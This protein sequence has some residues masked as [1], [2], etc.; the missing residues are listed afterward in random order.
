MRGWRRAWRAVSAHDTG[1]LT[2]VPAPDDEIEGLVAGVAPEEWQILDTREAFYDRHDVTETIATDPAPSARVAVYAVPLDGSTMPH[3]AAPVLLSYVD[4]VIQG[5]LAV[6]GPE[7]VRRFAETTD[8]WDDAV[9]IDD[10]AAPRYPRAQLLTAEETA[11]V[12]TTL[13]GLG[14]VPVRA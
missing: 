7:G 12:D 2:A 3:S 14:V 11:L 1:F 5:Y 6:F 10:R 4:V 8:G 13:A 9:F